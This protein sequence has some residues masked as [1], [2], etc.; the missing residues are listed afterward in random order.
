MDYSI[1]DY[2]HARRI[3][4]PTIFRDM[5]AQGVKY[6]HQAELCGIAWGTYNE[7]RLRGA[8][9]KHSVGQA[10]LL[11]HRRTCGIQLSE[12]RLLESEIVDNPTVTD[13]IYG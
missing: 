7:Y 2:V 8:E 1:D 4:W 3:N 12:K 6:S 13:R 5:R 11:L 9:P 10:I